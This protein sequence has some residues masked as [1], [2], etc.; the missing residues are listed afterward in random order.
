M[1]KGRNIK[2]S[3]QE[4]LK[5]DQFIRDSAKKISR[6]IRAKNNETKRYELEPTLVQT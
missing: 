5:R 2:K 3:A 6:C 1:F 4:G